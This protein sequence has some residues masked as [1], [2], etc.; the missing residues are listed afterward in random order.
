M[1]ESTRSRQMKSSIV[2]ILSLKR[3][4]AVASDMQLLK[5]R[6]SQ[7]IVICIEKV[8]SKRWLYAPLCTSNRALQSIFNSFFNYFA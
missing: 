7:F 1:M 3:T 4:R 8:V 2:T 6:I 5:F